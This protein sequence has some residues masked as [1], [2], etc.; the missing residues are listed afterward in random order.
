MQL[1]ADLYDRID[2]TTST[3]AKVAAVVDY[4]GKAPPA[5]AA[6][7]V[8]LLS[9][10]RLTRTVGPRLLAG[11]ALEKTGTAEW[12]FEECYSATGDLAETIALLVDTQRGTAFRGAEPV[13][14]SRWLEE[15]LLPLRD[16]GEADKRAAV[17]AAWDALPRRELY[18]YCKLLTGELRVGMTATLAT[19]A[20]AEHA[21]LPPQV[22]A[23]RMMG[24]WSPSAAFFAGLVAPADTAAA[25]SEESASRPY[26]FF[27]ASPLEEVVDASAAPKGDAWAKLGP[28]GDWQ[29][30]WKWDGIRAQLVKRQGRHWL[31]SRGEELITER[32]PDLDEVAAALPDGTVLD[33]EVL[34][35]EG[36]APL[37][38]AVLQQRIGRKNLSAR[39][40]AGAPAGFMAYDVL[41]EG[42][43]DLRGL[44]QSERRQ[45]LERIVA[46]AQEVSPRLHLSPLVEAAD[47]LE[48]QTLRSG[49]RERGV[50][51]F[52]LKR[53]ASAYGT[54][55]KRGDWFKWKI[56]PHSIDA[57]LVAAQPGSGRRA[58]VL[59]DL[60]F[61]VWDRGALVTVAKAYSGLTDAE[62]DELDRWIRQHTL[63]RYGPV[64][65]VEPLQVFEL[66]FEGI[67]ASGRHKSGVAV[68][69][70]RIARWRKDK[71]AA[72][73][74]TLDSLR[75]LLALQPAKREA[76]AVEE[77]Q[78]AVFT[79]E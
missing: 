49:S 58:S 24:T 13:A 40:L 77:R 69:F 19:R 36:P 22:V 18:L 23:L 64:R 39:A 48:L 27:L 78:L 43:H 50:E 15:R 10:R 25:E 55:R 70:P 4:L 28:L 71:P 21:G 79:D 31:W 37:S 47:W 52:M 9:G 65:A 46:A 63:E 3:K 29:I 56:D 34:A 76:P 1:L 53:R 51:G 74:D 45:R 59:T 44:Q 7:A 54:G 17:L 30:E 12:M 33:G 42:G 26:P 14:L 38:F 60:T 66:H 32:F 72:E 20:V 61:A 11:W 16:L 6:W 67:A 41:E 2:S 68:R 75:A 73:A 62:L 35:M 57:V 5:D 8:W